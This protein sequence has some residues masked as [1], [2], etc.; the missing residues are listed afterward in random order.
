MR[1]IEPVTAA[2]DQL[3]RAFGC[4]PSGVTAVCARSDGEPVGLAASS[5]T[6]VSMQ[7]PLVSVCIQHTST[8]W[9]KLREQPRLGLS[10]LAEGQDE[11]CARLA[12][13]SGDRF[14]GT[15]WFASEDGSVFVDD[16]TLWLDCTIHEEVTCGD[17]DIVLLRIHGL[18]VAP[19]TSPLVFHGSR[20]RRLATI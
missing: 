17:H 8:T 10:V 11:I 19:D 7:P 5:F 18:S 20:F 9:P 3:R 1:G 6:S 14:A 2:P 12:S 13:K 16:A 4:F 15:D